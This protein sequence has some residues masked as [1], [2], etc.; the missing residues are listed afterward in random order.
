MGQA[1][2]L[3]DRFWTAIEAGNVEGLRDVFLPDVEM[4]EAGMRVT[5]VDQVI[6][7]ASAYLTAFPD[8]RHETKDTIESASGDKI[9]VELD[10]KG[11]HTGPLMTPQGEVAATG[12]PVVWESVD[13]ITVR[14]GKIAS[15]HL[16]TDQL[17]FMRQLGLAPAPEAVS[18]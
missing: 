18:A 12:K 9:A 4:I 10:V 6:S 17:I 7:M 3:A 8:L 15:W 5:G 13:Y 2:D 11:T 14:D 16:Y 1:K